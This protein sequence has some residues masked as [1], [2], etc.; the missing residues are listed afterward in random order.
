MGYYGGNFRNRGAEDNKKLLTAIAVSMLFITVWSNIFSPSDEELLRHQEQQKAEQQIKDASKQEATQQ[1]KSTL[2]PQKNV[3]L[4]TKTAQFAVDVNNNRIS[5][6]TLK[7]YKQHEGSVANVILLDENHYI[8]AGI[9]GES[10]DI[11]WKIEKQ[12]TDSITL[13]GQ[14][15]RL[16]YRTKYTFDDNYIVHISQEVV[17]EKEPRKLAN[18]VRIFSKDT[19]D[20]IENSYAW[21]GVLLMNNDNIKEITYDDVKKNNIENKTSQDGWIGFSDQYWLTALID[22]DGQREL[23][24]YAARYNKDRDSY[25]I[26]F[27]NAEKSIAKSQT[28]KS[29]SV[30]FVGPK[31]LEHLQYVADKYKIQKFDK[32]I[33][34]GMFYFISKPLLIIL[35]KLYALSGNFGVAIILLTILVRMIIFPLA[36]RSYKA[37]ARMKNVAPKLKELKETYANDRHALQ[38]ATYELYKQENINPMS[39]IVPMLLQIPVFLALYKVLVI[40]IEMRDAPFVGWIVDLSSKDPTSI[41]NLF[42]LL[43]YSVPAFLQIGVLPIFMGLTMFVQH[44][45]MP[46]PQMEKSQQKIFKWMPIILTFILAPMPAGLVL[47]WSCSNIFTIIQQSVIFKL[48]KNS[49]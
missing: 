39:A 35:K 25:Q 2:K 23:K 42:G 1:A 29:E 48:S 26:D 31:R 49:K 11:D 47:Y 43:P 12:T 17:S 3:Y 45:M 22:N 28:F 27:L 7:N 34:F 36:N 15:N 16:N 6:A 10:R 38:M 37:T 18:Y 4:E 44:L 41:F 9:L 32:A 40:S 5:Y 8:E 24:T 30:I 33:D 19:K 21:R 46:I 14:K 20:R 13:K